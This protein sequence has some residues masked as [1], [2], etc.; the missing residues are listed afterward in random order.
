[1]PLLSL[2]WSVISQASV[3]LLF[4]PSF[5][6][7]HVCLELWSNGVVSQTGLIWDDAF[8]RFYY[9]KSAVRNVLWEVHK[10]GHPGLTTTT[11]DMLQESD[12]FCDTR[13][14]IY[15]FVSSLLNYWNGLPMGVNQKVLKRLQIVQNATA[16]LITITKKKE[17]ILWL[18]TV[19]V[20]IIITITVT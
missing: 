5:T 7:R 1:M 12:Q 10:Q 11:L 17:Q 2:Q 20:I 9:V 8:I 13:T 4:T 15:A 19:V 6:V 14:V 18:Y 3:C 16:I